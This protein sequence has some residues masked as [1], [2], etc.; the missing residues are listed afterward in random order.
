MKRAKYIAQPETF[1]RH[2]PE[3]SFI[4]PG[5]ILLPDGEILMVAPW[6]RP[7][8]NFEQLTATRCR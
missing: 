7:P 6:G 2:T 1:I 5:T 3:R 4:G 8:A